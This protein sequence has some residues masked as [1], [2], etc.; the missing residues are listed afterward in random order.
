MIFNFKYL[1]HGGFF[2]REDIGVYSLTKRTCCLLE[3]IAGAV[4]NDE[5]VLLI[6]ETGV[7][8]TSSIQYLAKVLHQKMVVVNLNRQSDSS[9][10]LGG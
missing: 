5:P 4:K 2:Y 7:G 6:G 9:D 10:L 3:V 8:K 1:N